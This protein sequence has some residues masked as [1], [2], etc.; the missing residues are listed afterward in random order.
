MRKLRPIVTIVVALIVLFLTSC[1]TLLDDVFNDGKHNVGSWSSSYYKGSSSNWSEQENAFSNLPEKRSFG[2]SLSSKRVNGEY[3][4]ITPSESTIERNKAYYEQCKEAYTNYINTYGPESEIAYD[5]KNYNEIQGLLK[6]LE[7]S[8][9]WYCATVEELKE[10]DVHQAEIKIEFLETFEELKK[11]RDY[12]N[13]EKVIEIFN[14]L[15]SIYSTYV[16]DDLDYLKPEII[17]IYNSAN[18]LTWKNSEKCKEILSSIGDTWVDLPL[19]ISSESLNKTLRQ[20]IEETDFSNAFFDVSINRL[21]N[22][23]TLKITMGYNATAVF[24]MEEKN[25]KM[26]IKEVSCP[27][28]SIYYSTNPY[29][30]ALVYSSVFD[31]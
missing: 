11:A 12:G 29:D 28:I 7:S 27:L 14:K 24:E 26:V 31:V 18:K 3:A 9:S 30:I 1:Q 10:R 16:L 23:L 5:E 8:Y 15:D 2:F 22:S 20:V 17:E 13:P 4:K 19:Y 6:E 21:F 25:G